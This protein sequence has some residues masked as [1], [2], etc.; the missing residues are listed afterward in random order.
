MAR[1]NLPP[2]LRSFAKR[3]SGLQKGL[4][5]AD[6]DK[7]VLSFGSMTLI[8]GGLALAGLLFWGWKTGQALPLWPALLVMGVNVFGAVK[9]VQE[10]RAKQAARKAAGAQGAQPQ[11]KTP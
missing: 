2:R 1:D 7:G 8:V 5:V 9:L 6:I 4:E 11:R 3:V 10:T